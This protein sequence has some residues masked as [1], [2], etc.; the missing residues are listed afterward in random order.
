MVHL[1][2]RFIG[3]ANGESNRNTRK[4]EEEAEEETSGKY[5]RMR[6]IHWM[7]LS[8]SLASGYFNAP[9]K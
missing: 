1:A 4:E 8:K 5:E 7:W 6:W 3:K 2:I 9:T